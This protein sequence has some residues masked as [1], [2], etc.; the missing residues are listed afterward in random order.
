M[1]SNS[2]T[3]T[4]PSSLQ[5]P[6]QRGAV[7]V[8]VGSAV[9]VGLGASVS[10]AVGSS[11]GVALEVG[12]AVRVAVAVASVGLAE[13]DGERAADGVWPALA[14]AVGVGD[15]G[16]G[17]LADG[18]GDPVTEGEAETVAVGLAAAVSVGAGV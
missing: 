14:V 11:D 8:A 4:S 13:A 2:S 9:A 6:G 5:S 1:V 16:V 10:V 17:V 7:S 12:D 15:C 18:V 3:V